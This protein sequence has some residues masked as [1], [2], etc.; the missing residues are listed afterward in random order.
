M[1]IFA[2][3]DR[4][5]ADYSSYISSF[6]NIRDERIRDV[7]DQSLGEGALW[8]E[9]L[10]QLNPSFEPGEGIE[11]LVAQDV[12]HPECSKI[13]RVDKHGPD[14]AGRPLR[15]HRH[16]A[17]AVK[18][19]QTGKNYVLTTGTGSGKSLAYIVPIVDHVLKR[20]AGK[21][22][23]A[24]VVYPM[25][26]LANSQC[27]ELEKFLCN[28]YP[29][30]RGPVTFKRY[31]GQEGE[32]ERDE[33]IANPPDIILTNYVM[34]E[35][36]LTRPI[37]RNLIA[38]ARG[39]RFLVLDELHTYRGRQG[40]DVALL[41]RRV[42][43]AMKAPDM[44]CVG[45]SATLAGPGT[46]AE[47]RTEVASVA[48]T[49]FGSPVE[50]ESV[51]G[52][53]LRRATPERSLEDPVYRQALTSRV[54]DAGASCPSD[55]G[56]F[57]ADPL[58]VWIEST[59]GI[60]A[61]AETGR[62][63]RSRPR[64]ITGSE[65]AAKELAGKIGVPE[66][67][68]A[69]A[70]R[71]G[72]MGGYA[73]SDP[74]TGFP[75][76]A[77][78][79]HQ[80]ISRGDTVYASLEDE[81]DRYVT[82]YGQQFV[83]HDR[84]RVLLPLVFC[85]ECGQE[86]YCVRRNVSLT[87]DV[88]YVGRELSDQY[89]SDESVPGFLHL[90]STAPWPGDSGA[91][92]ERLP[93]DWLDVHDGQTCVR[94]DRRDSLPRSVRVNPRGT[95]AGAARTVHFISAPF[96]FCL[97][98]RV[99]YAA[100]T[101]DDFAKLSSLSSEGRSTATTLL[102]LSAIRQLRA[103]P[104][105]AV[106]ARK[107]LS[108]TDNRQD[109]SLQAG[110]FNDFIEIAL[111]RSALYRAVEQAGP[112]GIGYED[113]SQRVFDS[114]ALPK[115]LYLS[116]PELKFQGLADGQRAF[117]N[118]LAYRVY[119][120]LKRGWRVTSPN[121]EQCGLLEI[122]YN[123]LDDLCAAEEEWQE[124]HSALVTAR[125]ETRS[126]IARTL[127]DFMRRELALKVD[128]LD[129]TYHERLQQQSGQYLCEPWSF[130]ENEQFVSSSIVFPRR[131]LAGERRENIY[132]SPLGGF[133]RYL[134]RTTTFPDY[135]ATLKTD[136]IGA[137]IPQILKALRVAG[138][139]DQVIESPT[140]GAPGY[141][142]QASGMRW[143]KGDGITSFHDPIRVPNRSEEGGRTNPFFV[144]FYREAA[145]D[146]QGL[147]AREHTAQV[148]NEQRQIREEAFRKGQLP[149]LYCSPTMELGVD[150]ARLNVVNLRN[151]PPTP[152]NYAQRSGRAG[153]SGQPALVFSYCTT[154]SPHDQYFFKRPER[155]VAGAVAP[156]RLD[157]ANEDLVRAHVH[158]IWLAESGM[159]LGKSLKE[160]LDLGQM[161]KL[162]L[163][164]TRQHDVD[165]LETRSRA[166][167]RADR[168]LQTFRAQLEA[169]DWFRPEWLESTLHHVGHSF[170][171]ACNRWRG[172]YLA[173]TNQQEIQNRIVIDHSRSS[174][175]KVQAKRLRSEA[176]E[177]LR[178]LTEVDAIGQSDFYSYR[179]F[180]SEGFLPGYNFPRLPLSAYIPARSSRQRDEFVSRPRFLAIS[181]FGP[182][183]II[184]HEGA[185]YEINKAILPVKDADEQDVFSRQAKLCPACGYL[186]P[187]TNGNSFDRCERCDE[188][189]HPA[190]TGLFR[191]Q[192]VSTRRRE[193]ISSDEEERRRQ[194]YEIVTGVRFADYGAGPACR[195]A[196]VSVGA[197]PIAA[198]V[199]GPAATL[200][201]INFGWR[202]RKAK[203]D[204]GFVLDVERGYWKRNELDPGDGPDDPMSPKVRKVIPY[205]E[206]RRN[207]LLLTPIPQMESSGIASLM[208]ALKRGIQAEF[209]LEDSEI[210]AEPLPS[211]ADRRHV[212]L[213]E[214][215]EGGAGVLRRLIDDTDALGRVARAAL[216]TCHF[217][218]DTG[219][220]KHKAPFSKE[221]CE[222]A[223]YDCLMTYGNQRDHLELD[224]HTVK[225]FL[226]ACRNA[227]IAASPTARTRSE[228]LAFLMQF[229]ES[230]LEK[231]WLAF[232]EAHNLHL[233]S[234]AQV[235]LA[236]YSTR[237][238]FVYRSEG[239][240]AAIYVDGP[241]HD[242][243]DRHKRDVGVSERMENDGYVVIRFHH[244]DDWAQVAARF[245]SIFGRV[246]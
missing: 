36:I 137:I 65:G 48:S 107:L 163:L 156:P 13:F 85:R 116:N 151:I 76:F 187:I 229:A 80:F 44:Q 214:A 11:D 190:L 182:R 165:M 189:L 73:V 136:E 3:R 117:R 43:E 90:S 93:D 121:L 108:F 205:V 18:R 52:E 220:D 223:C 202:R 63:I 98:C 24:I 226:L 161:P 94:K 71:A 23:Q 155:M 186:H 122:H 49:L 145:A 219:V 61:D 164:A 159:S 142:V 206:D 222:A 7:V 101:K 160:L 66:E 70:I 144:G 35:L 27:G 207:C 188:E 30:E 2:F 132:V 147:E 31:T 29:G 28:G 153:R 83:P 228:Q 174:A 171:E 6:I 231:Q 148:P 218:P 16:Q 32:Q 57:V 141:Q 243:P 78:R 238:D 17:D 201:R 50:P 212:L 102:S 203:E 233:P 115:H 185:R 200:R 191:L 113:L 143:V 196:T 244:A 103:D 100:T 204:R 135:S 62:L 227:S 47:Q 150:I 170:D 211:E 179:Y 236:E 133:G 167:D 60:A 22:I 39:L 109:A 34:L 184:Y 114:L 46:P 176:E 210:A 72:L 194:G 37:E 75:V 221:D 129:P 64:S 41:V 198:L 56:A 168:V 175:E 232:L 4:L 92:M 105:L 242:Y 197:D 172:L 215:S 180:A 10:I 140:D 158:A 138:L 134:R 74:S 77:F 235:L 178:L 12:L 104:N 82:V 33:I 183:A 67:R 239:T 38:R 131:Q 110:H 154:G 146:L 208:S 20:G 177:Q 126:R 199:Y 213:Y 119:R 106:D 149:I 55:Y 130:D 96:P 230:A 245:P 162:P 54:A 240:M 19:A 246:L 89:R 86:Y 139:V 209:Q 127:L 157:L 128:Y 166:R 87:G 118:V 111:I 84:S 58:S 53:T 195:T 21:G 234:S 241:Y 9:P 169:T 42:R 91:E 25:N 88:Q 237:P 123:S 5:I 95:E 120:D 68:C 69:A 225:E 40:A 112:A 192:N 59:F 51:I 224:R 15:L 125:P 1:D 99:S 81:A 181:E 26:A 45:T 173:A 217:D 97:H 193:R 216:D 79:L 14:D 152:A 124:C 8:P